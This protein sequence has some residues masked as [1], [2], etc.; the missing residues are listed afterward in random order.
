MTASASGRFTPVTAIATPIPLVWAC[1]PNEQASVDWVDRL[2]R[3][4]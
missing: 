3:F 2:L 1:H 4:R